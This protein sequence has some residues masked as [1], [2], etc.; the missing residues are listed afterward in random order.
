MAD[1]ADVVY[2]V[3]AMGKTSYLYQVVK[4]KDIKGWLHQ[5]DSQE[6]HPMTA[7]DVRI[8]PNDTRPSLTFSRPGFK[9]QVN[10]E[11]V[12]YRYKPVEAFGMMGKLASPIIGNPE[13][14][15]FLA[16]LTRPDGTTIPALVERTIVD[17]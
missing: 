17:P 11:K 16:T 14:V 13:T 2:R 12:I 5:T 3:R 8:V 9:G 15:T 7:N 6:F 1:L 10:V 4:A